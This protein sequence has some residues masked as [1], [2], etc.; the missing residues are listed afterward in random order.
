M[1]QTRQQP[2]LWRV[3]DTSKKIAILRSL[4]AAN[5]ASKSIADDLTV[6]LTW[7]KRPGEA[8]DVFE[9]AGGVE[10]VSGRRARREP[11]YSCR[12]AVTGS[13]LAARLAGTRLAISVTAPTITATAA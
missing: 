2:S 10:L 8:T 11:V 13:I 5:S 12:R 3:K 6:L 7:A 1:T 9:Q 4:L